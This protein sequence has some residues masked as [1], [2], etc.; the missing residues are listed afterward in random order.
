[1]AFYG[2]TAAAAAFLIGFV[3]VALSLNPRTMIDSGPT[4]LREWAGQTF[5]SFVTVLVISLVVLIRHR[6]RWQSPC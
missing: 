4:G 2:V 6:T 1:M 3:F 5:R